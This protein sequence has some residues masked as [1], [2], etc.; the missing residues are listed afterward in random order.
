MLYLS[1]E[2]VVKVI[3]AEISTMIQQLKLIILEDQIPNLTVD[4]TRK[5]EKSPIA[6]W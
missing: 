4:I 1:H 5:T 2:E 3:Q 6:A